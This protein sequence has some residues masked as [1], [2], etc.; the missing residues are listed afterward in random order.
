MFEY[1][2]DVRKSWIAGHE[3]ADLLEKIVGTVL[4]FGAIALC[5]VLA[6]ILLFIIAAVVVTL[7]TSMS[8]PF[9]L[10]ILAVVAL[11]V[12]GHMWLWK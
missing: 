9:A 10:A 8:W 3:S 6:V 12:P 2:E 4:F 11:L 7:V 1:I 5:G